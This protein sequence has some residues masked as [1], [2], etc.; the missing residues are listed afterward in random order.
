MKL[1]NHLVLMRQGHAQLSFWTPAAVVASEEGGLRD[2]TRRLVR[3]LRGGR[4]RK[5]ASWRPFFIAKALTMC[6]VWYIFS[7]AKRKAF[8]PFEAALNIY[9][10]KHT[11]SKSL[12]DEEGFS[13]C[14]TKLSSSCLLM[15][16]YSCSKLVNLHRASFMQYTTTK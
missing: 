16:V 8:S 1:A 5:H 4:R 13:A 15:L 12:S 14:V 7:T 3:G 2:Y 10:T 9:Q 6:L 11:Y